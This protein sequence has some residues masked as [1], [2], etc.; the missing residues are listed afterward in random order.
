MA[1]ELRHNLFMGVKE[2]LNN[3][4]KHAAASQ[5]KFTLDFTRRHADCKNPR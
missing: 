4:V 3:A 2:A 1:A 5:I